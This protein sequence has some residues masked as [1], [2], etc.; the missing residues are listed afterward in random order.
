MQDLL[1]RQ[2][3]KLDDTPVRARIRGRSV[4]VTGAAGSIGS[5]ICRQ[6]ARFA[7]SCLVAFD[8]AESEL[9]RIENELREKHPGLEVV[10]ALGD[11]RD[12]DR[13][14][15]LLER[16]RVESV[17]HAAAYKH[18]PM[19]E[20]HVLEAARNNIL[21]TWNL[22]RAVRS[23]GVR[24]LLMISSDKAVNPVSVMGATKRVCERIIGAQG[25]ER[26]ATTCA[27]VR[28]GNVLGSNGSVVPIFQAQIAAGGPIKVTHPQARRYFMTIA[29]AVSLTLQASTK[30]EGSEI[31]V[32]DMGEPIRIV[33]LA[34]TMIRLAGLVPYEDIDIQFTGLRPGERLT[35]EINGNDEG[36]LATD[37]EK[38]RVIREQPLS[39]DVI[40]DWIERLEELLARRREPDIIAHI[41]RTGARILSP[42]PAGCGERTVAVGPERLR[43]TASLAPIRHQSGSA[44]ARTP[45]RL[46]VAHD[47]RAIDMT[48]LFE[49]GVVIV[50]I[51]TEQI[52][53]YLDCLS[54]AQFESR[55]PNAPGAH[56]KLLARL[57]EAR[58][59]AT[60]FVVGGLA[61]RDSAG[62]SDHRISGLLGKGVSVRAGEG[63]EARL[64]YCR[65]F[66]ERLRDACPTQE[67]GLHG[68]LTHL[69]W[70]DARS[71]LE[72]A[73]RELTEGI[74]AL[75]H[76]CGRPTS[77]SYRA[78]PGS[79][80]PPA[81]AARAAMLPRPS[82]GAGLAAGTN[83]ARSHP[84]CRGGTAET[85]AAAGMAGAN[86]SRSLEH[87]CVDVFLPDQ[88]GTQPDHRIAVA[89]RAVQAW[90]GDRG[91]PW[92]RLPLLPA[93]GKPGG[94][95]R[96]LFRPRR[97]PGDTGPGTRSRRRRGYDH[98]RCC[99]PDG[100]ET[101]L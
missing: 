15:E 38:M 90:D 62:A 77:F 35:E 2:T 70:T 6:V 24:N 95:A 101:I 46:G 64:W 26:V 79:L 49:R 25:A 57:Y 91:P 32:L 58:V 19:M 96:R 78:Q 42:D 10:A 87:S 74:Q 68:G 8:Q 17:F 72:V 56:V 36:I 53:G 29:E 45:E 12:T 16:H 4:L 41:R 86:G 85:D 98:E 89:C 67:I 48:A 20:S 71:T 44:R 31:F 40:P 47:L 93:S 11:I 50:S 73:R 39:W 88:A 92:C 80:S 65:A 43:R 51:D 18:V 84:A 34:E 3:V 1:G 61:L 22:L 37:Q 30:S 99:R 76:L 63:P 66:L 52:W 9:F 59:R 81:T 55:F 82:A 97:H 13:L 5:E 54:E 69:I 23:M 94:I 60:W 100:K 21:G 83:H 14:P 28:F 75:T 7:P 27:S 33:D